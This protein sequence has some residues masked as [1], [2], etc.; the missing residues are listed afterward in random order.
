[1]NSVSLPVFLFISKYSLSRCQC[2]GEENWVD[3]RTVYI[4]HKEPPPG[5]EA[6]IPQRYPDNRIVSSK[7]SEPQPMSHCRSIAVHHAIPLS[8]F[9]QPCNLF[10]GHVVFDTLGF[11]CAHQ[12]VH[13]QRLLPEGPSWRAFCLP[14][15]CYVCDC[16]LAV[17]LT[18]YTFWNFIPKN[19]FEQFRRIANFYFL[20]IFLV[21]VRCLWVLW[22]YN[23]NISQVWDV[24]EIAACGIEVKSRWVNTKADQSATCPRVFV[25]SSMW[26]TASS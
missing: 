6:Y 15:C 20:V 24:F 25:C 7:V 14:A 21:Q 17:T 10:C 8:R 9:G 3:S 12:A 16:N 13:P 19:L 11:P 1:M 5:A 2:V 23:W 26:N 4:G 22:R 18:Q